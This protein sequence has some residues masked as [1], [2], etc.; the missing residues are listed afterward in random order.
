MTAPHP[1]TLGVLMLDTRFP[2]IPGDIGAPETFDFPV[3]YEIVSGASVDR[4]VR[5]G[6]ADP[7]LLRSFEAASRRLEARGARAIVTSCGFLAVFQGRLARAVSVP[8]MTSSLLLLPSIGSLVGG[9][10]V[11][12]VVADARAFGP[13]HLEGAGMPGPDGLAVAGMQDSP[14]FARAILADGTADDFDRDRLEAEVVAVCVQ[15][16]QTEPDL[17][18]ILFECTNLPPYAAAVRRRLGVP[19]FGMDDC[20]RLLYGAVAGE[21]SPDGRG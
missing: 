11:G 8:V 15:L 7:A 21:R 5:E 1:P 10:P 12:V 4:V 17:A 20:A 14:T 18:A 9:R 6:T 3:D 13:A 16:R 2:R 19:V